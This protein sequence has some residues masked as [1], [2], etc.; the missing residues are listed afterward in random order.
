MTLNEVLDQYADERGFPP[1]QPGEEGFFMFPGEKTAIGLKECGDG[2]RMAAWTCVGPLPVDGREEF[3]EGL[4]RRTARPDDDATRGAAF[5]ITGE[6][7]YIHRLE[8][9]STL[10]S[11]ALAR[12]IEDMNDLVDIWRRKILLFRPGVNRP[13]DFEELKRRIEAL[14]AEKGTGNPGEE[15]MIFQ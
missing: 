8:S 5:S 14:A 15:M 11:D 7:L 12:L 9:L 4:L 6:D 3:F 13:E 1:F 2:A 10:D